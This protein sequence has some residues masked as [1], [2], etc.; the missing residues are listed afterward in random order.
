MA[1]GLTFVEVCAHSS[2]MPEFV[3]EFA[4]RICPD[5]DMNSKAQAVA[6]ER[7]LRFRRFVYEFCW[8]RMPLHL[9]VGTADPVLLHRSACPY[10]DGGECT[11]EPKIDQEPL[12]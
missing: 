1:G 9:R 8:L 5:L 6:A 11:C 7:Q 4:R 3:G 10:F 2:A 12:P